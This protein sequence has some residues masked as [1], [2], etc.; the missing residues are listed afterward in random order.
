MNRKYYLAIQKLQAEPS[1]LNWLKL[2]SLETWDRISFARSRVGLKI[3]ETTITQNLLLN[4][5]AF[6]ETETLPIEIF[7]AISEKSNGN[8]IE[9]VIEIEENKYIILPCQAK[10]IKK[11]KKYSSIK[12]KVG[13][14]KNQID[15]LIQYAQKVK[16]IPIYLFYNYFDENPYLE[17]TEKEIRKRYRSFNYEHYGCSIANAYDIKNKFKRSSLEGNIKWK[18]PSFK[19]L[20]PN[21]AVPLYFIALNY[22]L[23]SFKKLF[24]TASTAN[25]LIKVYSRDEIVNTNLWRNLHSAPSIGYV[26]PQRGGFNNIISSDKYTPGF[27]VIFHK[28]FY[29]KNN[30]ISIIT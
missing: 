10:I 13:K 8:D 4:I 16:G 1:L 18:I 24:V 7:E 5:T 3:Y 11:N 17:N 9:I 20:H 23:D 21:V 26:T 14:T 15:L 28:G 19:D 27:R 22:N 29:E 25:Q 6:A 30:A 12:H 2:F